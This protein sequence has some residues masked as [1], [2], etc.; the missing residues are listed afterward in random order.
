[1][2]DRLAAG[3]LPSGGGTE[4]RRTMREDLFAS[5]QA[6]AAA[7]KRRQ[8]KTAAYEYRQDSSKLP[9]IGHTTVDLS[10][11]SSR[12]VESAIAALEEASAP[13]TPKK[14][15]AKASLMA[16]K[17]AMPLSATA[18]AS[19]STDA[20][21]TERPSTAPTESLDSYDPREAGQRE[22]ER[23]RK[24]I[25]A[26]RGESSAL[27]E[28]LDKAVLQLEQARTDLQAARHE[29]NVADQRKKGMQQLKQASEA[30]EGMT[31]SLDAQMIYQLTLQ[32]MI[33]RLRDDK[34]GHTKNLRLLDEALRVQKTELKLQKRLLRQAT[35]ARETEESNLRA[36]SEQHRKM[37]RELDEKLE[38]RGQEVALRRMRRGD[39]EKR[40][41]EE[42][43]LMARVEGD[44]TAQEEE[45]LKRR[46]GKLKA[47]ARLAA[48][49]LRFAVMKADAFE[50]EYNR[51]RV[52]AGATDAL[53]GV[54][55]A[56]ESVARELSDNPRT[57]QY[58][59]PN[60]KQVIHRFHV[61]QEEVADADRQI[62]DL[63]RRISHLTHARSELK[64][65]LEPTAVDPIEEFGFSRQ[66]RDE[67]SEEGVTLK[68]AIVSQR[69]E[70]D[71]L[72]KLKGF[73]SQ[74]LDAIFS[75]LRHLTLETTSASEK[76]VPDT[77]PWT[78]ATCTQ[79]HVTI[80]RLMF[81]REE[82]DR[83]Q[84]LSGADNPAADS[85]DHSS[86]AS[87]VHLQ[88]SKQFEAT[89]ESV[90]TTN[91]MGVRIL[92]RGKDHLGKRELSSKDFRTAAQQFTSSHC[93]AQRESRAALREAE[94][95]AAAA[96][97]SPRAASAGSSH[98]PASSPGK[99]GAAARPASAAAGRGAG[100]DG[101]DTSRRKGPKPLEV[102]RFLAAAVSQT[103]QPVDE[104]F[105]AN[106][107][108]DAEDAVDRSKLKHQVD[109]ERQ[110]RER[111]AKQQRS[112]A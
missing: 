76:P 6:E 37:K 1:M 14:P 24:D 73:L 102:A 8:K 96:A 82:I 79:L 11:R 35:L 23:I 26:K 105:F 42:E 100:S 52:A 69:M 17:G 57:L 31:E 63:S 49:R 67:L 112:E 88:R 94:E 85:E 92:P 13:S 20:A 60:P 9:S 34:V 98:R 39:R 27:R 45:E 109:L 3:M 29:N 101:R 33:K 50:E 95:L 54:E 87:S 103:G 59:P 75:R 107:A 32:H 62:A 7:L 97:T 89:I 4:L 74:S 111:A 108:D 51:V 78:K 16:V 12:V 15:S 28:E 70:L 2:A 19:S 81:V 22:M 38:A 90:V 91:E 18:P 40:M 104:E 93:K 36:I 30:L 99:T 25:I 10:T 65:A 106:P 80:D 64:R 77:S 84:A 48:Q 83:A 61:V 53:D 86:P 56:A 44:L 21:G 66:E 43:S 46:A 55:E 72:Q 5:I 47:E 110:A 41:R 58:R 71:R 68:R